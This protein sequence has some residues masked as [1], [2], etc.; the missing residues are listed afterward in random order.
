MYIEESKNDIQFA[1]SYGILFTESGVSNQKLLGRIQDISKHVNPSNTRC[2]KF[3]QAQYFLLMY[4]EES[5]I[6][7]TKP[8]FQNK[9]C[10]NQK[11]VI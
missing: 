1:E 5:K 11:Q 7:N 8:S 9:I 6:L 2:R 3:S 10:N 4:L